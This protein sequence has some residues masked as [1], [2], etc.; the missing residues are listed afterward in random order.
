MQA[1]FGEKEAQ[2]AC[3]SAIG[4][5]SLPANGIIVIGN[6]FTWSDAVVQW[7]CLWEHLALAV[8]SG[9]ISCL[10]SIGWTLAF[11]ESVQRLSVSDDQSCRYFGCSSAIKLNLAEASRSVPAM[12]LGMPQIEYWKVT[13]CHLEHL[14]ILYNSFTCY[15]PLWDTYEYCLFLRKKYNFLQKRSA[16]F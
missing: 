2:L 3:H 15:D 10:P 12:L 9:P 4:G 6:S 1:C 13:K 14:V 11:P 7:C 16:N 5:E 8:L